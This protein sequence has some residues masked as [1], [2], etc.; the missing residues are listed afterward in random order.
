MWVAKANMVVVYLC[1]LQPLQGGHIASYGRKEK[2]Q[3]TKRRQLC[4]DANS[5]D[6]DEVYFSLPSSRITRSKTKKA[7]SISEAINDNSSC[8]R[9]HDKTMF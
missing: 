2:V 7:H 6:E 5:D 3:E 1:N 4:I 8:A 9:K